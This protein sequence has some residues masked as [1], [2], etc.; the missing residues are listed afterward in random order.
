M[1]KYYFVLADDNGS[2][3]SGYAHTLVGVRHIFKKVTN[4]SVC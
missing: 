4:A 1:K 2:E 3:L